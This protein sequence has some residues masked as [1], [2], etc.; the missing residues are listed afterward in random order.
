MKIDSNGG[1]ARQRKKILDGLTEGH[2]RQSRFKLTQNTV[3]LGVG[4]E[5]ADN[6]ILKTH[7]GNI[8][9]SVLIPASFYK[10]C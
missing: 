1:T 3:P 7:G 2:G 4:L 6:E 5:P 10:L 8:T 9:I